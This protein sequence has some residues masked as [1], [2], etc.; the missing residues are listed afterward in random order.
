MPDLDLSPVWPELQDPAHGYFDFQPPGK[1]D[2][3][4]ATGVFPRG[5]R[6]RQQSNC[7]YGTTLLLDSDGYGLYVA[8]RESHGH[9]YPATKEG[10]AQAKAD[11][12]ALPDDESDAVLLQAKEIIEPV[13]LH[14]FGAPPSATVF[15]GWGWHW[16]Y[17]L[18]R[19]LGTDVFGL[20]QRAKA[21][22]ATANAAIERAAAEQG[23]NWPKALDNTGDIGS[24]LARVPGSPNTKCPE[25]VRLCEFA[26]KTDT[27]LTA[28][29]FP[30]V[31]TDRGPSTASG[32]DYEHKQVDFRRQRLRDGRSFEQVAA[33]LGD[34]ER[35]NV[36]CPFGGNSVGSGF[37]SRR[38][39]R[40]T[41]VSVATSARYTHWPE[42]SIDDVRPVP[43]QRVS[44][45]PD[46][47]AQLV[48][49]VR[50]DG[51]PTGVPEPSTENLLRVLLTDGEFDLWWDDFAQAPMRGEEPLTDEAYIDLLLVLEDHYGWRQNQ[52]SKEKAWSALIRACKAAT[53]NPLQEYLR[54]LR[55]D[56]TARLDG[57]F[58]KVFF[59][60][61][62][63]QGWAGQYQQEL[64]RTYA[65]KWWIGLVARAMQPGVKND[66]MLVLAGTQ[67]IGKTQFFEVIA[68]DYYV[69]A[70]PTSDAK[71]TY[72][73][74]AKAWIY[75]DAELAGSR[76][77]EEARKALLSAR[78]DT[79]RPPYA[80]MVVTQPRHCVIVGN[81]NDA[82]FLR[83]ATGSRRYWVV[84]APRYA[85]LA[86][87]DPRQPRADLEWL[88]A[89]RDQLLAEALVA[90]A[91]GEQHWLDSDAEVARDEDNQR[92]QAY[93]EW[94]AAA[95]RVFAANGGGRANA[96][97]ARDFAVAV[98]FNLKVAEIS[99]L[100]T[101]LSKALIGAGFSKVSAGQ[102][103]AV[104][105]RE[106]PPGTESIGQG[107][108]LDA[109]ARTWAV[110]QESFRRG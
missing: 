24:R 77:E 75:D 54:S 40:V 16:H 15:S 107:T 79:Y 67:G 57:F 30:S 45:N 105:V 70:P 34:G 41:Y 73:H 29:T 87:R 108:G 63:E 5:T 97:T 9:Q 6:D 26:A 52:P 84:T 49:G 47:R 92:Y 104:Y 51:T 93:T 69:A 27:V 95:A 91:A 90:F 60:P 12:Y 22:I 17:A 32:S 37:F 19:E 2:L 3:Y 106:L 21:V 56:G 81:T 23:L 85:Y 99:K 98:D 88:R 94:D 80:R 11:F 4:R 65:R 33:A 61:A 53:R 42:I 25:K 71:D 50:R 39:D 55:W 68:G 38:R 66:V 13:L 28:E 62:A 86:D 20:S 7:V 64:Y 46:A 59:E 110:D 102:N 76:A 1:N 109:A 83:D 44:R 8:L 82:N 96:I 72:M 14:I 48:M 36:V 78:V 74:L 18:E 43:G 10:R 35:L 89:N 103:K 100:G 31:A 58:D 101:V